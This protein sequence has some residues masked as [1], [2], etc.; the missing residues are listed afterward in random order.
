MKRVVLASPEL[1]EGSARLGQPLR[2]RNIDLGQGLSAFGTYLPIL[3]ILPD[4]VKVMLAG[5]AFPDIYHLIIDLLNVM[6]Y[7]PYHPIF[8]RCKCSAGKLVGSAQVEEY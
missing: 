6:V 3:P 7:F 1:R 5:F 8:D 4:L 2:R